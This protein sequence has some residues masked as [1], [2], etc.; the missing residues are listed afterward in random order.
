MDTRE[1]NKI[2]LNLLISLQVLL[3]EKSVSRAAQRLFITQ[4]AMSKTLT[5]LRSL[6]D[7]ELFTRCSHGMQPTPR[8]IELSSGLNGILG[9]IAHLLTGPR[10]DPR[11]FK[12]EV[13]L[14]LSEYIGVALLPRLTAQL[15]AQAPRLDLRV[16]TRIED[17]LQALAQGNLD[18]VFHVKQ[19]DYSPEYRVETVGGGPLAIL[20]R[21]NHPLATEEMTWDRLMQFPLIKLYASTR[22]Q[23]EIQQ[24]ATTRMP[25]GNHPLGT[26]EISH[27]LTAL[28]VLRQTDYFMPAP[29]FL[30]QQEDATAGI[31]G[32]QLPRGSDL[33]IEYALVA[34]RRTSN[35]SLHNW[36]WDEIVRTIRELRT[37]LQRKMRQRITATSTG[38]KLTP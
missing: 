35:S 5:R 34:H 11:S 15:N 28:E 18:F 10:F 23:V 26:L 14:A 8:A 2:D 37:P 4:S 20:I 16:I 3:E 1:F 27:L 32:L 22:E 38:P 33:N 21:E 13:A 12:G 36:L 17:P 25:I 9:D 6:F 29:A 24:N 19:A 30:L 31:V 7:D